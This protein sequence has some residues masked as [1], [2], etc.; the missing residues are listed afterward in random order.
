MLITQKRLELINKSPENQS[1][2]KIIDLT[3]EQGQSCGTQI[4][5]RIKPLDTIK[6][7][8]L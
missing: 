7:V 5:I 6:S 8:N 3:D 2:I 4:E 1:N